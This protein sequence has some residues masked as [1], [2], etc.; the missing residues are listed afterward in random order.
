ML[1]AAARLKPPLLELEPLVAVDEPVDEPVGELEPVEV[2]P[3]CPP[4][5]EPAPAPEEPFVDVDPCAA[6]APDPLAPDPLAPEVV[7]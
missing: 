7:S 1:G 2:E 4:V 3:V 6:L 5:L